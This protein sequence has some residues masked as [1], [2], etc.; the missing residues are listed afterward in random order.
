[1]AREAWL[2]PAATGH[3]FRKTGLRIETLV[4]KEEDDSLWTRVPGGRRDETSGKKWGT[5]DDTG[6]GGHSS[7]H[8]SAVKH[9]R[10]FQKQLRREDTR[11]RKPRVEIYEAILCKKQTIEATQLFYRSRRSDT[12][13]V[14]AGSDRKNS[15]LPIPPRRSTRRIRTTNT[16]SGR[17]SGEMRLSFRQIRSDGRPFQPGWLLCQAIR[18]YDVAA[19][20][21]TAI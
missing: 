2:S 13:G 16:G 8:L 6:A 19:Q 21:K 1:M 15:S 4:L 11:G 12:T 10:S 14:S 17:W 5:K 3:P 9:D 20:T 18:W 7:H